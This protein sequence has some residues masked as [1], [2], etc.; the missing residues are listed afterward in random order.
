MD[1]D[2]EARETA[3]RALAR[4][5]ELRASLSPSIADVAAVASEVR[6]PPGS[7]AAS[8]K[9][10]VEA[11]LAIRKIVRTLEGNDPQSKELGAFW[12]PAIDMKALA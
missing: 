9:V 11:W 4:L 6:V 1:P 8:D 7:V 12:S 2:I 10:R 5:L 3:E